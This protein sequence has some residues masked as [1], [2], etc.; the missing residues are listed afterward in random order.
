MKTV[1]IPTQCPCCSGALSVQAVGCPEC[2][3]RIEGEFEIATPE[4]LVIEVPAAAAEPVA[5]PEPEPVVPEPAPEPVADP[6]IF[7][8]LND[9]DEEFLLA[10]L[11]CEGNFETVEELLDLSYTMVKSRLAALKQKLGIASVPP[12]TRELS[13]EPAPAPPV[14]PPRPVKPT[15]VFID[16]AEAPIVPEPPAARAPVTPQSPA[17][18]TTPAPPAAAAQDVVKANPGGFP[19]DILDALDAG[20]ISYEEALDKLTSL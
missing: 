16:E 14:A 1:P 20:K 6:S 15:D 9:V 3:L 19:S 10:F 4:P 11:Q 18:V 8:S 12:S 7:D 13:P 5:V 2:E 17:T